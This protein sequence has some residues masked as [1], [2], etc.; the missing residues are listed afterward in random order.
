MNKLPTLNIDEISKETVG[1]GKNFNAKSGRFTSA[2][3]MKNLGGGI[4]ELEPGQK[5]W[6][7]T[8]T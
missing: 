3:G 2:L 6:P 4:V 7:T 5:P 8:F 1:N